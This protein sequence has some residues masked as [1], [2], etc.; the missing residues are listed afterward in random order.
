MNTAEGEGREF[1]IHQEIKV[2]PTSKLLD[3]E[4]TNSFYF[5]G[6]ISL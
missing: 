4:A 6:I 3:K 5:N 2:P 1:Q